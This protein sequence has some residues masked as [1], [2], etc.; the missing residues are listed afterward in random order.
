MR[1][2]SMVVENNVDEEV[3]RHIVVVI[4]NHKEVHHNHWI[5]LHHGMVLAHSTLVEV[6]AKRVVHKLGTP[7][8]FDCPIHDACSHCN[9]H[10]LQYS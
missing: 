8:T 7:P 5:G 2:V 4:D 6:V 1:L 9:S 3:H 10:F